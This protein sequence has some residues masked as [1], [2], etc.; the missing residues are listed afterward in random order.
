MLAVVHARGVVAQLQA[1][2]AGLSL[3]Y[4]QAWRQRPD[5]FAL[6]PRLPLREAAWEGGEVAVFFANLLPEGAL[7]D[8][9]LRL[10][11]VPAGNLYRQLEAF[12]REAAGAFAIVP[13]EGATVVQA[14]PAWLPYPRAALVEDLARMREQIPL[15]AQHP[16]LRLSL[17]GAQNKIPL[18]YADGA[19]WLPQDGAASTHILKPALQPERLFPHAV[20]NEAFCLRLAAA[21]G[22]PV[23]EV[24]LLTDPEP[25]LLIARYDRALVDGQVERLHQ[26]DACQLTGVLP[27]LK[28]EADGGPGFA[29]CFAM[30]DACSAAPAVDRLQ[31]V[32]WLLFNVLIGNADA[33]GKNVSMVLSRDGRLRLAP[34]YD[35]LATGY[36]PELSQDMAMAIGGERR[37]DWVQARHWQA[38]CTQLRLNPTQLRRRALMLRDKALHHAPA[39]MAALQLPPPLASYL[40]RTLARNGQ[41][42]EQRLG[43]AA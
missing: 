5:A 27:S 22:L 20:H 19:L 3:S 31:L 25:L 24:E 36:W 37:P 2:A 43:G 8:T 1:T 6:S 40:T 30:L 17:A 4:T 9:L 16:T 15:L 7:L 14:P 10:Q 41:R 32:D 34:A 38:L 21:V 29:A 35:L 28:Y 12:G 13:A 42:L 39:L 23:P 26:L 33:H 11:R 18:R